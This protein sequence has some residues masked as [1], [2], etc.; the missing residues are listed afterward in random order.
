MQSLIRLLRFP[1]I[2]DKSDWMASLKER[3]TG[4]FKRQHG[5]RV[6]YCPPPPHTHTQPTCHYPSVYGTLQLIYKAPNC[7]ANPAVWP[8]PGSLLLQCKYGHSVPTSCV[9]DQKY[10]HCRFQLCLFLVNT[11]SNRVSTTYPSYRTQP[12]SCLLLLLLPILL[13]R[14]KAMEGTNVLTVLKVPVELQQVVVL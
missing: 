4:S 9:T 13:V 6:T 10:T 7:L 14:W 5:E 11:H 8:S 12:T 3:A 2:S 1:T